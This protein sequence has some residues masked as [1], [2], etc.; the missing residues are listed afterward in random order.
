M[1]ETNCVS[2]ARNIAGEIEFVR[3]SSPHRRQVCDVFRN[4]SAKSGHEIQTSIAAVVQGTTRS[5]LLTD[6]RDAQ[7]DS[8]ARTSR[9]NLLVWPAGKNPLLQSRENT[10]HPAG[11]SF[12]TLRDGRSARRLEAS[13]LGA[14][15]PVR[16]TKCSSDSAVLTPVQTTRRRP[17]H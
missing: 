5:L 10:I 16:D 9:K 7:S 3:M 4:A 17:T 13:R 2:A 12:R 6:P 14:E 11:R 8:A 1:G 15:L